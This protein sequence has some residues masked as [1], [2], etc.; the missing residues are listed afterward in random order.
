MGPEEA[1]VF[2]VGRI[3]SIFIFLSILWVPHTSWSTTKLS[4]LSPNPLHNPCSCLLTNLTLFLWSPDCFVDVVVGFDISTHRQG[5]SLFQGHPRLESYLPGILEDITSI[6]GV[7]CGAGA[8]TQV[9][10]AFKVNSEQEFPAKFQI[11][12][13]AAFNS[14]L[15]VTVRGPTH[16]NAQFLQSLWD[17]FEERSSSRGQVYSLSQVSSQVFT[18]SLFVS[19]QWYPWL[20]SPHFLPSFCRSCSSSQTVSRVKASLC[21]NSSQ[22]GSEKQVRS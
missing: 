20:L 21:W 14:L 2:C 4:L 3:A 1:F 13:K 15:Q 8:D 18:P 6:R 9:S 5:Q 10:L 17:V 12:Q 11:Y 19:S 22:T 7:S 16:L